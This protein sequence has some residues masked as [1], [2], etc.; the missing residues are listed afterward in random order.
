[1][2]TCAVG[3]ITDPN[4]AQDIVQSGKAD[5][6]MLGREFL[7][8]PNWVLSAATTLGVELEWLNQYKQGKPKK[9]L[10]Y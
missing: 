6:V 1:M 7:R 3:V 9:I 10:P 4:F 2:L 8:N 5:A